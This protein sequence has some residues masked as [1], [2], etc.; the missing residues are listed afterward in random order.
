MQICTATTESSIEDPKKLKMKLPY[1]LAILFLGIYLKK[2]KA[3]NSERDM[4]PY[5]HCSIIYNS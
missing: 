5:V 4:H 3:L 2:P 1:D